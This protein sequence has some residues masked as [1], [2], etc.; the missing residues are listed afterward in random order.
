MG[1]TCA[2]G[3]AEDARAGGC[4]A[5]VLISVRHS[6]AGLAPVARKCPARAPDEMTLKSHAFRH[7]GDDAQLVLRDSSLAAMESHV[8][9]EA[10]ENVSDPL[11]FLIDFDALDSSNNFLDGEGARGE[12]LGDGLG[13]GE[14]SASALREINELPL[15]EAQQLTS[16]YPDA[17]APLM[18]VAHES[19]VTTPSA[20]ASAKCP[21]RSG[22]DIGH[23]TGAVARNQRGTGR[24]S[25]LVSAASRSVDQQ[26]EVESTAQTPAN[27]STDPGTPAT[28]RRKCAEQESTLPARHKAMGV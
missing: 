10:Q 18:S 22:D 27:G 19:P 16:S 25:R 11:D 6:R 9:Y 26:A 28:K 17:P 24:S 13:L 7:N 20:G 15:E 2:L 3:G 1:Y 4:I 8:V 14:E 12:E 5:M 21:P 23:G